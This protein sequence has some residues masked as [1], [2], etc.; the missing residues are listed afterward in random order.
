[1]KFQARLLVALFLVLCCSCSSK[2][3]TLI[4]GGYD[5]QEMWTAYGS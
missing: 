1:M 3:S 5:E 2:P 4:E